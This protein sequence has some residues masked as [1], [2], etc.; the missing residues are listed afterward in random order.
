MIHEIRGLVIPTLF[1]LTVAAGL[2]ALT[3]PVL[4][5]VAAAT[6]ALALL[7]VYDRVQPRHSILRNYPVLGHL[8][9]LLEDFGPELHQYI[10]ESNTMGAPFNRDRRSLMYARAKGDVDK[11]AF[12]T[13]LNVYGNGYVWL[14]HSIAPKPMPKDPVAHL[15]IDLGGPACTQ[16]YSA[17]VYNISAMS[18]GSLSA[19][20]VLALNEG[21]RRGDFAHNTGEGGLSRYHRQPGGDLIWQVGTGYFGCRNDDGTFSAERFAETAATEA[22][23]AIEIKISQGAKPGH[24]GI[25]PGGKVSAEIAE[26]RGVPIGQDCLSPSGHSAFDTPIGLLEFVAKLRELSGAKPIGFKLCIGRP[27][28]FFAICKAM[29]ET[30]LLPDF[31]VVD[32]GE[33]GTGAAPIEFSDHLGTPLK[34]GLLLVHNALEGIGVRDKV[35]VGASG[36]LTSAFEMAGALALGADWCN[37]ARGFMFALG[38]I[39]A[40]SCHT[41]TCP[42]GVTTQDKSLARALVPADKATRVRNYHANTIH[43]LAEVL[44]AAGLSHSSELRPRHVVQ[45]LGPNHVETYDQLYEYFETGQLLEGRANATLQRFWDLASPKSFQI[46][47]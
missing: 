14:T 13:E 30:E 38:C 19:N 3:Y 22:V 41:N 44:G 26:A 17:S 4:W 45:R 34:E 20:A 35:K 18:F 29:V 2:G 21:A 47:A 32:G 31:I 9:F 10:V 42:V 43:A 28:E 6:G 12:G 46:E 39:Q 16:P 36:K 8:R 23:R 1:I 24:G 40:Q 27:E 15:R 5:V 7:G 33:G 37:S 25:L 11:K